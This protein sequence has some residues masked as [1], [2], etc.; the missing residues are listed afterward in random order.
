MDYKSTN[1]KDLLAIKKVP[2]ELVPPAAAYEM[3]LALQHGAIKYGPWNWRETGVRPEVYLGAMLRHLTLWQGG[4]E[5]DPESGVHHL[6]HVLACC[7]IVLDA[8]L[9]SMLLEWQTPLRNGTEAVLLDI[10]NNLAA[11]KVEDRAP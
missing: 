4:Q 1:P 7:A 3:A 8:R 5:V 2:L 6:G 10:S 11:R 9:H